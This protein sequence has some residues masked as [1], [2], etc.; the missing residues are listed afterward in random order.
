MLLLPQLVVCLDAVLYNYQQCCDNQALAL[1]PLAD[2]LYSR[3]VLIM[4][5]KESSSLL[6]MLQVNNNNGSYTTCQLC[7]NSCNRKNIN[8]LQHDSRARTYC[9]L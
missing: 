8:L 2:K 3:L 9:S 1:R 4:E 7:M 6:A 5:T